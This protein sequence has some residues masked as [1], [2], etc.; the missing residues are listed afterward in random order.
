MSIPLPLP[1]VAAFEKLGFGLFLHWGLY[2]QMGEG[3]WCQAY[4][5]IPP[6]EYGKLME[7]FTAEEFDGEKIASLA[8]RAG[9]RYIVLT[10]RHHEGFSLYDTRGLSTFDSPH[11]RRAET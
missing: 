10:T 9:M 3:E 1:R 5:R 8:R 4:K 7:T 11:S 6:A 2:S